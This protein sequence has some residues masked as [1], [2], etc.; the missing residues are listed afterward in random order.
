MTDVK[1][2]V[3]RIQQEER[4]KSNAWLLKYISRILHRGTKEVESLRSKLRA[5]YWIVV[6][7][8]IIMFGVGIALILI[9]GFAA[10]RMVLT[11]TTM[12]TPE[13]IQ[14]LVTALVGLGDLVV[15]FLSK[16]VR[17]VHNL[18][19]DMTQLTMA[20]NTFRYQV[21]LRLLEM[22]ANNPESIGLAAEKINEAA[23][24]SIG[25]VQTY[26]EKAEQ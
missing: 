6:V 23:K 22:D 25:L 12:N 3:V 9:P 24:V 11:S 19:G 10:L 20:I 17:H 16:P 8:S 15:L 18:M 2:A 5:T 13:S 1:E 21:G 4:D 7:L 26:F 14:S